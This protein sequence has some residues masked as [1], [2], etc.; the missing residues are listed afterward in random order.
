MPFNILKEKTML[1]MMIAFFSDFFKFRKELK[2][3]DTWIK[4]FALR[5]GYSINPS[6]MFYTNLKIWMEETM[7]IFGKR[8]CPCFEPSADPKANV[9]LH[10]PCKYLDAEL[11]RDG[12]CHCKLFGRGDLTK[13]E[14]KQGMDHLMEEYRVELNLKDNVLDTRGMTMDPLRDL[15]IPDAYHQVKQALQQTN[16]KQ[17]KVIMATK[18][19]MLNM[20]Q[21]ARFKGFKYMSEPSGDTFTI[22]LIR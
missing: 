9:K 12:M 19:E 14:W 2:K 6:W 1:K 10:C 13:E 3:H 22:T 7:Q 18:Q 16:G 15:P 20:E 8:Y 5:K 4:K 17:L 11:E 21:F